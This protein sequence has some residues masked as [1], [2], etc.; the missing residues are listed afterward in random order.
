MMFGLT[1]CYSPLWAQENNEKQGRG[2]PEKGWT[3]FSRGAVVY[4]FDTDIDG[5]GSYD[6]S[7]FNIQ[8]GQTYSWDRRT[9]VSLAFDYSYD[10]YSFSNGFG[11]GFAARD[12]WD[13]INTFSLSVPMRMGIS[14][15][16]S[17]FLIPSVRSSGE[18][19]ADFDDTLTGGG[20]AGFSYRFGDRLTLGPGIGIISQLEESASIFPVLIVNWKITDRLSL[21]TGRGLAASFGP[22]LTLNYRANQKWEFGIGGRYEKLRFRLDRNGRVPGGIGEDSSVPLFVNST[23]SFTPKTAV[24]FVGG[25]EL[26]GELRLEDNNGNRLSKESYDTG[27]FLGLTYSVRL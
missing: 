17:G 2:G 5:G 22:G 19:G 1:L 18:S 20:F 14:D 25:V 21:E 7:R 6:S 12:P 4:Q 16:W 23:Y 26:D 8:A 9:S 11:A 24:S 15:T 13:N 27:I 3:T 10:G